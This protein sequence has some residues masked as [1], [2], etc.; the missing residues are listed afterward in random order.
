VICRWILPD[1]IFEIQ[2]QKI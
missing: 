2:F 1:S